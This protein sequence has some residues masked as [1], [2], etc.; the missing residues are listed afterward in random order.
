MKFTGGVEMKWEEQKKKNQHP[1][2][3]ECFQFVLPAPLLS[4]SQSFL[5]AVDVLLIEYGLVLE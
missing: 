2:L 1:F 4:D 3:L 5:F